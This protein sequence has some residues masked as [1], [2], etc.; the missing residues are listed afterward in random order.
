MRPMI[1]LDR[2]VNISPLQLLD[3]INFFFKLKKFNISELVVQFSHEV[4]ST[5]RISAKI[6]PQEFMRFVLGEK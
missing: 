1:G 4:T 3:F 6:K 5:G 2:Q